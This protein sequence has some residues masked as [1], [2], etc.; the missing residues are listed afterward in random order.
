MRLF[1]SYCRLLP[2]RQIAKL[3]WGSKMTGA[4]DGNRTHVRSLGSFYIAII[5]RPL[6]AADE[7]IIQDETSTCI[8]V[9]PGLLHFFV[10]ETAH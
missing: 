5:R 1:V 10:P 2:P 9:T 8:E 3:L 7:A 6:F 4:G